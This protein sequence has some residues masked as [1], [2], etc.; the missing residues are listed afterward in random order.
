[1]LEDLAAQEEACSI[2]SEMAERLGRELEVS[3]TFHHK[4]T[5]FQERMVW[6]SWM[7]AEQ[8]WR[9]VQELG[10]SNACLRQEL[11]ADLAPSRPCPRGPG[12]PATA[13]EAPWLIGPPRSGRL[14]GPGRQASLDSAPASLE[15]K[16]RCVFCLCCLTFSQL[17]FIE[18]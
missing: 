10:S 12:A 2:Y 8:T 14:G 13:L 7:A 18:S 9:K 17:L 4:Q 6:E 11:A 5:L 3:V 15:I 1:M 16:Q